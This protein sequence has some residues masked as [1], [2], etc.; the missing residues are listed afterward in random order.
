M[1]V[2]PEL[3]YVHHMN[4]CWVPGSRVIS[5]FKLSVCGRTHTH[6]HTHTL[7]KRLEQGLGFPEPKLKTDKNCLT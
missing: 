3:M 6:T 2:L 7:S 5:Y 4:T 1:N